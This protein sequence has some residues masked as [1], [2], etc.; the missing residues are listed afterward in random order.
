MGIPNSKAK[1]ER[2]GEGGMSDALL[3]G[4]REKEKSRA[5]GGEDGK[6]GQRERGK[7]SE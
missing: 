6:S 2:K 1:K 7:W 5:E 4:K 3:S